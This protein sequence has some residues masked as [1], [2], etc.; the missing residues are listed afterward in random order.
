[1][2]EYFV[3]HHQL[4]QRDYLINPTIKIFLDKFENPQTIT[5]VID[6]IKIELD[7]NDE[8]IEKVCKDFFDFLV[9]R[10]IIVEE[11]ETKQTVVDE[12]VFNEGDC[13]YDFEIKKIIAS[14]KD[15]ELYIVVKKDVDQ[16]FVLKVLN[17]KKTKNEQTFLYETGW[18]EREYEFL[19][20]MHHLPE[21][22]KAHSFEKNEDYAFIQMEYIQ[23]ISLNRFINNT[24]DLSPCINCF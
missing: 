10:K 9:G 4:K 18:L 8:S 20:I 1:M 12:V 6:A 19:K 15:V 14:R 3:L 13:V 24:I 23:G 17:R 5:T 21:I 7:S 16:Q 11:N 22:C 2:S